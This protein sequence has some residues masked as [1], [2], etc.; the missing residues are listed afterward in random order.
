M[1]QKSLRKADYLN[2]KHWDH[3]PHDKSQYTA[4]KVTSTLDNRNDKHSDGSSH[5]TLKKWD[6][7]FAF[8]EEEDGE[9]I[10][11]TQKDSLYAEVYG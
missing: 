6:R 3:W 2:V 5:Q 1:P 7:V 4:I 8:L 11:L 10:S 9:L